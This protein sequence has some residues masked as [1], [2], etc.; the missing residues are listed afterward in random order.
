MS[1]IADRLKDL[2]IDLPEP[3]APVAS[4]VP[5]IEHA[6]VLTIS[7]QI[8]FGPAGLVTG[9]LGDSMT[10]EEGQAA[11]RLCG[12]MLIAQA[13]AFLGDLDRIARVVRLGGF[14]ASTP[15]FYDQPKVI[16]GASDLMLEVF[17]EA[18]RH[19]RAAVGCSALPLGAAV[20]VEGAFAI[21]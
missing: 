17:G 10:L 1:A 21:R 15:E 3:A 19:A 6:G 7:G 12:L 4:Y 13:K 16:N 2:G 14:V 20:E 18:G 8:S 11:A 9:R 5:A